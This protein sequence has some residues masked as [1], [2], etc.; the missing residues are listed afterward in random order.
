[1]VFCLLV[2]LFKVFNVIWFLFKVALYVFDKILKFLGWCLVFYI[3]S[4]LLIFTCLGLFKL[5]GSNNLLYCTFVN[6]QSDLIQYQ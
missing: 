3:R 4:I 6:Q 1:M 5:H 2:F